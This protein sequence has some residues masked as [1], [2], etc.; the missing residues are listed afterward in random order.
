MSTFFA[1]PKLGLDMTHGIILNWLVKE[2][3]VL[4]EGTPLLEIE[5]DKA[6]QEI[7]SPVAGILAKII[8][9][10]GDEVPCNHILAV[11]I[12]PGEE[13]PKEIPAEIVEGI[14]PAPEVGSTTN[15]AAPKEQ[16]QKTQ[17]STSERISIS[18]SANKLAQELGVDIS[19]I[20]AGG[21]R[22]KREHVE[23][24]YKAMQSGSAVD[25]ELSVS[26]E[27]M[28]TMHRKIAEHMDKSARSVARVGLTLEIDAT[29][30]I[31]K[32]ENTLVDGLKISYTVFLAKLTATAL[33]E[34][35]YMNTKIFGDEIWTFEEV[36]IGI[37]VDSKRGLLVPVLKQ[38][39]KKTVEELHMEFVNMAGRVGEGKSSIEDLDG[40]TFTITNL[41][42]FDIE[43]FLPIINIPECAILGVGAIV[44]KPVAQGGAVVI[45][46][47]MKLTLVFDHRLVDG[48]PA[49]RF[50]QRLKVLIEEMPE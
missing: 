25:T 10:V 35:P 34:F 30:I 15:G 24:A 38:A 20:V 26:K 18:P 1:M 17:I 32:R 23:A 37:A 19:I 40:G 28:S 2:G 45:K 27:I 36:N 48:A 14:A 31:Q 11:I 43:A 5:T 12:E 13:I 16:K 21:G 29:N 50:L 39:N 9:E 8:K 49:A 42:S 44:Q 41:G 47:R 6:I 4:E 33:S 46:P 7:G 3:D 22:I